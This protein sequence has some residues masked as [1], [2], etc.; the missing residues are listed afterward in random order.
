[1]IG[2]PEREVLL[3]SPYFVPTA[4]GTEAFADIA[5]AGVDIRILT[6][7]L[8]A[9]DVAAVH[10]GY[11][12]RRRDLLRSG[13]RLY[14]MRRL[15]PDRERQKVV[16]PLGSSGSS[17]HAKTYSVDGERVYVGS[18][19]FDPRSINLNT[20]LGF[21]IDSEALATQIRDAFVDNIPQSAY[22][23]RFDDL[24]RIQW[25]ERRGHET[26]IHRREPN[27]GVL[28]RVGVFLLSI[29]PIEWLL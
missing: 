6:N 8:D 15:T 28:K 5:G 24:G 2:I 18:F 9:T 25:L 12:K 21:V 7:S 10:A 16:G 22:E 11:A 27:T 13:I 29:L 26:V 14:E 1:I 19:N 20:E 23:V 17:L 3:I 4:A